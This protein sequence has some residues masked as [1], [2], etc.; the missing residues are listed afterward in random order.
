[1]KK[2]IL[3]MSLLSITAGCASLKESLIT[4][5]AIGAT[6]GGLLGN[7][8]GT[9]DERHRNTNKGLLI[10]AA[11]GAGLSYLAYQEKQNK[12]IVEQKQLLTNSKNDTPLLTR[13]KIKR[14][15]VDD[16]IQG[17]R[18]VRGHWEYVIEEQSQ[19]STK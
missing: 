5:T 18:F 17:K 4:G 8:L 11:L 16:K 9:G 7:S 1:M 2:V 13:P 19:W 12:K 6:G 15:W 14:V 3:F 10:G